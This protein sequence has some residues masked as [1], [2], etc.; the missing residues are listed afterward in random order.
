[1]STTY[2]RSAKKSSD[3]TVELLDTQEQEELIKKL[4]DDALSQD[5]QFRKLLSNIFIVVF[6]LLIITLFKFILDPWSLPHETIYKEYLSFHSM[7]VLYI[8]NV[9]LCFSGYLI[10]NQVSYY[11]F[12]NYMIY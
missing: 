1:M 11:A 2:S 7:A 6:V 8:L 12:I 10:L 5:E 3:K 4:K 9:V